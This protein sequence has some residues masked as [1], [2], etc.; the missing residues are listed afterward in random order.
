MKFEGTKDFP[1]PPGELYGKLTDAAFLVQCIPGCEKVIQADA[2]R[3]VCTLRP[4][5][6]YVRGS[7]EVTLKVVERKPES[8]ARWTVHS[9]GV[10]S[11]SDV[12]V[13]VDLSRQDTV[14]RVHWTAEVTE[15]GGLLKAVPRGLIQGSAQKVIADIWKGIEDKLQSPTPPASG[16]GQGLSAGAPAP[17]AP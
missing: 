16:G 13:S 3:G 17:H 7:L 11:H 4:G 1:Q 15:L 8:A 10:G 12:S 9:K 14:T 2:D 5:V 6:S